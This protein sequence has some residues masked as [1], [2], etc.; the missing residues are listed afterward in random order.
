MRRHVQACARHMQGA[1]RAQA[2]HMEA[3]GCT[4][5]AHAGFETQRGR[6]KEEDDQQNVR[7]HLNG[8]LPP[9]YIYTHIYTH[10]YI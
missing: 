1:C 10:I 3:Y 8:I 5:K 4:L 2:R 9:T 7:D 6:G